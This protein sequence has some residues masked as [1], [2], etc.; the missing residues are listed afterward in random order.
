MY[1][2]VSGIVDVVCGDGRGGVADEDEEERGRARRVRFW[3]RATRRRRRKG[4]KE[5]WGTVAGYI[6]AG[7][8]KGKGSI[9]DQFAFE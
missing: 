4:E 1:L 9:S 5:Q 3:R 8:K 2:R 6:Y 7:P